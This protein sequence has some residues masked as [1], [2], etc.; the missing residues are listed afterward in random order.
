MFT[1]R[2]GSIGKLFWVLLVDLSTEGWMFGSQEQQAASVSAVSQ[3]RALQE[4]Q[5]SKGGTGVVVSDRG[6]SS[7]RP[8]PKVARLDGVKR[9]YE[10]V[11]SVS[12]SR[13]ID[14]LPQKNKL[15]SS[16]H[17]R[18]PSVVGWSWESGKGEQGPGS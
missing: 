18:S 6:G 7:V 16:F 1:S 9:G 2:G 15:R 12:L 13:V 3:G 5:S 14:V 11:M 4:F 8:K 17:A 10:G